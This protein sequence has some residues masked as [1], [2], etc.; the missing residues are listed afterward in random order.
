MKILLVL[1]L[2]IIGGVGYLLFAPSD[3]KGVP[4]QEQPAVSADATQ[5]QPGSAAATTVT[6]VR[7]ETPDAATDSDKPV[8]RMPVGTSFVEDA[9]A[10]G[11]YATGYTQVMIK[12]RVGKKIDETNK[13]HNKQLD[14]LMN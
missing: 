7:T 3:D 9:A 12:N 1:L 10:V 5:N 14:D 6:T 4:A 11:A 13:K 8:Q 2:L